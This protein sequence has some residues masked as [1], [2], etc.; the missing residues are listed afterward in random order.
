MKAIDTLTNRPKKQRV[1]RGV[2]TT[3]FKTK[4]GWRIC[5]KSG[6]PNLDDQLIYA[7]TRWQPRNWLITWSGITWPGRY[8]NDLTSSESEHGE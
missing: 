3:I 5:F 1:I 4:E 7:K 8:Q 6:D 2:P